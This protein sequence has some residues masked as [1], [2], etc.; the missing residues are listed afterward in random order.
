MA[1]ECFLEY[2]YHTLPGDRVEF[3]VHIF[4]HQLMSGKFVI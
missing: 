4:M 2:G 3:I 1:Y